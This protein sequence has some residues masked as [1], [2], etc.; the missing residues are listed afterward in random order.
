[1]VL[2][3]LPFMQSAVPLYEALGFKRR[4]AYHDSPFPETVALLEK[5][6]AKNNHKCVSC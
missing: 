1:M 2:D 6:G 4:A 5:M 3:T